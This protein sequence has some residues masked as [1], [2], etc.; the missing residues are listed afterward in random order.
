[1]E[2]YISSLCDSLSSTWSE[3]ITWTVYIL[4]SE[5]DRNLMYVGSTNNIRRRLRQHSGLITG[6]GVYTSENRP[7]KLAVLV[8]VKSKADALSLEYWTKAKNYKD[9][10]GIPV[11]DPVERRVYLLHKSMTK[12]KYYKKIVFDDEMK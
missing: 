5:A 9:K 6:G 10:T 7:W 4:R 8:P 1:M 12:H 3:E 11:S 2:Q